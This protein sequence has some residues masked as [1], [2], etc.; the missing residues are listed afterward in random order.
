MNLRVVGLVPWMLVLSLGCLPDNPSEDDTT[1]T[2]DSTGDSNVGPGGELLG[3]PPGGCVMVMAV[4]TLDDRVEVFVPDH[5]DSTYRGAI[6]MDLKPNECAGC[7]LGDNNAGRLDEPFGV[8]RAGSFLH[9]L[10]G[11]YPTREEGS[12]VAFP[13]SFFNGTTTGSTV[14]VSEYF[15]GG[16]FVAPVVGRSLGEVEPIFMHEHASGRLI[17]G[18]FNNDLFAGEDT[19]T[20]TGK[21]L[22]IDPAVPGGEVGVARLDALD[23]GM[24]QGASQVVTLSNNVLGVACD[25]NEA[26]AVIDATNLDDGTVGDAADGLENGFLCPLPGVG[27]G[28][29]VRYL[30]PDGNGGFAVLEGPTPL[31]SQATARLWHMGVD[32]TVQGGGPLDLG[33]NGD[34]QLGEIVPL[35][36]QVPTWMLAAGSSRQDSS[37][38]RGVFVARNDGG[39]L[40]LCPEPIAGFEG[41]WQTAAG[42]FIEPFALAVTSDAVHLAVGA[43]PY[44]A[45]PAGVGYGKV[46]WATL[47]GSDTCS[48]TA[49][50]IDLTDGGPGHAPAPMPGDPSTFRRGPN[51]VRIQEIAG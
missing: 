14:A 17:V 15:A 10:T 43:G 3:C 50:V 34:W 49:D 33:G 30:A 26:V 12:L 22:V 16:Q 18:V 46:L 21:L 1:G 13:L 40:E 39:T 35:P 20:Q 7:G 38:V 4:Q 51:V 11:H 48:L 36:A 2:G 27:M 37:G 42:G 31:D 8:A 47:S 5:P 9:V 44:I 25:G 28:K 32:C 6:S 41:Q 24:C 45:D 29:R 23:G 19:W